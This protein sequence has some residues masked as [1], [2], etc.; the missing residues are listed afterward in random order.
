MIAIHVEPHTHECCGM[1]CYQHT[2]HG[3]HKCVAVDEDS[4]GIISLPDGEV[5]GIKVKRFRV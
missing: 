2:G 3:E 1:I 5:D 4:G